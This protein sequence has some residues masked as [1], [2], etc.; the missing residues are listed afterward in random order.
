MQDPARGGTGRGWNPR[1]EGAKDIRDTG[2]VDLMPHLFPVERGEHQDLQCISPQTVASLLRGK[3]KN[4]VESYLIIDCRYPYEYQGGHIKGAVNIHSEAQ[5]QEALFQDS[6]TSQV[7]AQMKPPSSL[8]VADSD[9]HGLQERPSVI[10]SPSGGSS[11]HKPIIFHCEFSIERGPRLCRYLREMDRNLNVYPQLFYPELYVL[12]GGYKEFHTRFP[13]LCDPCGYIPMR[14]RDFKEQ[15]RRFRGKRRSRV[16][17][18]RRKLL[19]KPDSFAI[20]P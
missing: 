3:Y 13:G 16:M 11:L 5:L 10:G 18:P 15:L 12:A 8:P 2:E 4:A 14:H 20:S 19:L 7:R 9:T 1:A 6:V 17:R